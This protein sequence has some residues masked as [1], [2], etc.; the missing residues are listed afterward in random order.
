VGVAKA[1]N[2]AV[3]FPCQS[4]SLLYTSPTTP[5]QSP[6]FPRTSPDDHLPNPKPFF[7]TCSLDLHGSEVSDPSLVQ[8]LSAARCGGTWDLDP[9]DFFLV[10]L[11]SL[12]SKSYIAKG[13]PINST[14][15]TIFI[16]MIISS[17]ASAFQATTNPTRTLFCQSNFCQEKVFQNRDK[18]VFPKKLRPGVSSPKLYVF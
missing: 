5:S 3:P 16:H 9:V 2:G 18:N 15:N 17:T 12:I 1:T 8:S 7:Q 6:F 14:A 4:P 13:T 10:V 11:L